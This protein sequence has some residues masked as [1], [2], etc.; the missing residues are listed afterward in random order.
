M[1]VLNETIIGIDQSLTETGWYFDNENY[2]VIKSKHKGVERLIDIREVLK[3]LIEKFKV[4]T[5]VMENYAFS[6]AFKGGFLGELG[7]MIKILAYDNKLKMVIILPNTLK[8]FMTGKGNSK[9][10]VM[11]LS[12]YKNYNFETT[13][14]NIVDAFSLHKFYEEYLEWKNGKKFPKTKI[15]CF[16]RI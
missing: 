11:L 9:K 8:K 5:I 7:G 1:K 12:V 3:E 16:K 6:Q 15:E 13:N 2:D 14:N 10:E 4:T